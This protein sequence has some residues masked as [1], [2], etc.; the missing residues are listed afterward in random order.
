MALPLLAGA[1]MVGPDF[2]HPEAAKDVSYAAS[3]DAPL[4]SDQKLVADRIGSGGWW[5]EFGASQLDSVV[6]RALAD[7]QD[8]A[9][10]RARVAEAQELVKEATGALLPQL[11]LG[12]N[13]TN[14]KY[15][16]AL[17][18]PVNFNIP[19]FTAYTAG[20]SA[21]FPTD[22]F[23]GGRRM[24]EEKA[25]LFEYRRQELEAAHLTLEGN[26]VAQ[27]FA[28]A[29]SQAQIAAVQGIIDSD[30]Q[31]VHLVETAV[32]VGSGTQT[33][34]VAAQSQLATDRTLL[35]DLHQQVSVARHALAVLVGKT[36]AEW[37]PPDFTLRDFIL[38]VE[39]PAALPSELA[40]RRP[41]ILAAEAQLHAACAD[42]GVATANLYPKLTLTGGMTAQSL[43]LG[44]P[45]IAA[46]SVA[47]G[48]LQPVFDGGQLSAERRASIQRYNAALATYKQIV[49]TAF[50]EVADRL[51]A[52]TN[53]ADQL[54]AQEEAARTAASALD[55]A[56]RSFTIGNTGIIDVIDAQRR[57]AQA[58]LG[59]SRARAQRL[60][61]T[62]RLY[63]ALGGTPL[64][65]GRL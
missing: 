60:V 24:V 6:A 39:I 11:S 46:W 47:A 25:A 9:A 43:A 3:T 12:A 13:A 48:L 45:F 65:A 18:G 44:G 14:T 49:L 33:Q 26:V 27:A 54:H 57:Y 23:G 5:S 52:L 35:P 41:D 56:R 37:S 19:S 36:P 53:D 64:A 4:P 1:C 63:L 7:N 50:G 20:P 42:I 34:L 38:P 62:A 40:H 8:V 61:D 30:N 51:Q 2:K 22:L 58:Q 55:L 10:A 15:G 32:G 29:A 59:L 16:P 31:N 28:L 21:S 17:F